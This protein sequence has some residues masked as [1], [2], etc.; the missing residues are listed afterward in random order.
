MFLEVPSDSLIQWY[1]S[2]NNV[3]K[4]VQNRIAS[5]NVKLTHCKTKKL[6]INSRCTFPPPRFTLKMCQAYA[7]KW[8]RACKLTHHTIATGQGTVVGFS[9]LQ[10]KPTG[11]KARFPLALLRNHLCLTSV[12]AMQKAN[13]LPWQYCTP[14]SYFS[15][16]F[17]P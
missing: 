5:S 14:S 13:K 1:H 10:K 15:K 9:S 8:E 16:Q 3:G 17:A 4:H 2:S 7:Y 11:G 12:I 6:K